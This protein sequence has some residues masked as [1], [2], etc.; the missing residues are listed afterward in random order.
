MRSHTWHLFFSST[1]FLQFIR[2]TSQ[3]LLFC[4]NVHVALYRW[5]IYVKLHFHYSPTVLAAP[6]VGNGRDDD[7]WVRGLGKSTAPSII[8]ENSHF[9][10]ST[11]NKGFSK[12]GIKK[13]IFEAP[14]SFLF[15]LLKN[16]LNCNKYPSI[17]SF[18]L[19]KYFYSFN[20]CNIIPQLL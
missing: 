12:R 14:L 6:L 1:F 8:L 16:R 11:L 15:Y 18:I 13:Y 19:K 3:I 17:L 7:P 9:L 20:I 5:C 4:C 10:F 2:G